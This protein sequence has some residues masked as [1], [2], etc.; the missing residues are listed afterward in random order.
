MRHVALIGSLLALAACG[1]DGDPI[2][3][4]VNSTVTIGSDGIKTSTGVTV[5]SG[6]V[7]VGVGF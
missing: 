2:R 7:T 3:P 1:A 6:P 5:Q 4:S